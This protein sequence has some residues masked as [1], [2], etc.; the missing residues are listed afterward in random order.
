MQI[1]DRWLR[2]LPQQFLGKH[3]I[4]V[5]IKAFARQLQEL[6]E[7]FN[8]LNTQ[9]DIETAEGKNLDYVGTIFPLSRK[10]AGELAGIGATE[11][12]IS[13]ERYRR[14]MK[15][16]ILRNT[17]ECTYDDLVAGIE[18]LWKYENIHYI[19]DPDYPATIIF[20]TSRMELDTE[21]MTEFYAGLCIR[22]SGVGV[23]LRKWYGGSY[24][25]A[26]RQAASI[27]FRTSFYPRFNLPRLRLDGIWRL[28]GKQ[29]L[30]GYDGY[31]AVDLYP[32]RI[33]VQFGVRASPKEALWIGFRQAAREPVKTSTCVSFRS[34]ADAEPEPSGRVRIS[35][36]ASHHV[37]AG[38]IT[39]RNESYLNGTWK[40]DGSRK[41]NGGMETR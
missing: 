11:P 8:D 3:N 18:L 10:E 24:E 22:A 15:Y 25:V 26:V 4:E 30:S 37:S 2:D 27:R 6:Q 7:V 21:D 5:L 9:L 41:L 13:D 16:K 1:A 28:D 33:T 39:I 17:S 20:Q 35:T 38:D 32:A 29:Q 36:G 34:L 14:F 19:E 40:L 23:V 31:G 12:V